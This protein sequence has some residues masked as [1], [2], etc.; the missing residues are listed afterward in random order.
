MYDANDCITNKK[1][2][3]TCFSDKSL[4]LISN[5]FKK[6]GYVIHD[7]RKLYP[8][9]KKIL[10]EISTCKDEKCWLSINLL[11]QH[12]SKKDMKVLKSNFKPDMPESWKKDKETWLT[13]VDIDNVLNRYMENDN[14]YFTYGALPIDSFDKNICVNDLC[15]FDLKTHIDNGIEKISIVYN[16]DEYGES[17]QHWICVY[18]DISKNNLQIPCIYFFDSYGDKPPQR[19]NE[20]ANNV[21]QQGKTVNIPFQYTYNDKQHQSSGGECGVYCLHFITYMLGGGNF[22]HYVDK[23]KDETYMNKFRSYFYDI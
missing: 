8:Q 7:K 11:V 4:Q 10:K 17:G 23:K 5:V 14:K 16:T 21:I 2:N 15:K 1:S 19:V 3:G 20:F 22:K 13:T 9:I 6:Q 12:L 18:I